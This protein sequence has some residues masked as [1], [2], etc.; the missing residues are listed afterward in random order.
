MTASLLR[1]RGLMAAIALLCVV[2]A[3]IAALALVAA[4]IDAN[5]LRAPLLRFF[6]ARTGRELR[7][8]G[9]IHAHLA[10]FTPSIIAERV[11]IGN[12][13]W[14][15]GG[16]TADIG[17]L[18][19]SFELRPLL[20]GSIVMPRLEAD[21]A[22]LH[23]RRDA[24]GHSNWQ[25]HPPGSGGSA[26]P[27]IRSLSIPDARVALDDER[28]HLRFDGTVSVKD[29][30]A[31][32][33][34][35][36]RIEGSGQLNGRPVHFEIDG[37][38]LTTVRRDRPYAFEFDERS[39]GSQLHGHGLLPRPFDFSVLDATFVAMGEDLKDM[40]FLTGLAAPDTG[41]YRLAGRLARRGRHFQ[42]TDL[43][44]SSGESDLGGTLSIETS[45]GRPRLEAQ[46]SSQ[47]LRA[48]DLGAR[49]AGRAP[50]LPSGKLLPDTALPLGGIRRDDGV[51]DFHAQRLELGRMSFAAVAARATFDHAVLSVASLSAGVAD[52][53]LGGQLRFDATH[54]PPAA[55]LDLRIVDL[56]LGLLPRKGAGPPPL[57]GLL[58]A[59]IALSAHGD[60]LHELAAHASGEIT[61]LLPQG[62]IRA[63]FA[64]LTGM[65]LARSLGMLLRRDKKETPIRCGIAQF[66]DHDG[67]LTA[68]NLVI[69]SDPVLITGSGRIDLGAETFDLAL[70][71]QPK[72]L[73]LLRLHSPVLVRGTL[74]HPTVG[75]D[76]HRTSLTLIDRGAATDADCAALLAQAQAQD[77]PARPSPRAH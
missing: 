15:P 6:V 45:A 26:G 60:S 73:R 42:Y 33:A 2:L 47:L 71:G 21:A 27:L 51:I 30:A 62:A 56:H 74:A 59:R 50:A 24:D 48:A 69:D 23:L 29:A 37:Q 19:V 68:Q 54:D 31:V 72:R 64:E 5:H 52:G 25:L 20:A 63:S 9:P 16:P 13:P 10:S 70:R 36:L 38:A 65:D 8:D 53:R 58:Q 57:D 3:G 40:Y 44:V 77:T 75:I 66:Q 7:I 17:R 41:A 22:I 39:S 76:A 28:R 55:A 12:P 14:L 49:A 61:A 35:P 11:Q 46:L 67:T 1:R 18:T 32:S 4:L 34:L 43:A